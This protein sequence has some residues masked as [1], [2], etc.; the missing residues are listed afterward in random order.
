MENSALVRTDCFWDA[1]WLNYAPSIRIFQ[2]FAHPGQRAR[3]FYRTSIVLQSQV[4]SIR[5]AYVRM[6]TPVA[7]GFQWK[8]LRFIGM[9]LHDFQDAYAFAVQIDSMEAIGWRNAFGES[10]SPKGGLRRK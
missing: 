6:R 3:G 5:R 2:D 9:I 4:L 10:V 1:I 7:S 8:T